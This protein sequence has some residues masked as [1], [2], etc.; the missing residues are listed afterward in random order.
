MI[1]KKPMR[2]GFT[3]VELLV[4][5]AIIG[6]LVGLLLPAVQAAREAAR[7]MSCSNNLKQITL[8]CHNYHDT[9]KQWPIHGTG[10]EDANGRA[11]WSG[12]GDL[13]SINR[14]G[15]FLIGVLPFIEQQ[16]LWD[17]ISNPLA[18]ETDGS[19]KDPAWQPMGPGVGRADYGP[20]ATEISAFRCPSDPGQGL[21]SL[22]RTNYAANM[23]DSSCMTREGP[24]NVDDISDG[25]TVPYT[26]NQQRQAE[27]SRM[28][29]RG[30]FVNFKN[31]RI[32][33]YLDGASNTVMV[34]E[35][36]TDLG[37]L[38]KRTSM[39]NAPYQQSN[40]G[41]TREC[42][43]DPNYAEVQGWFNPQR[44]QFWPEDATQDNVLDGR[45]FRW[46][47]AQHIFTQ[48]HT[49]LPPNS[50]LCTAGRISR[51]SLNP[52][53]SRHP[54]GVH[55]GMADG[56]VRFITDSIESGNPTANMVTYYGDSAGAGVASPYGLWGALGTRANREVID[57]EF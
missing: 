32:R 41:R 37:D 39:P 7:R 33:D 28:C 27:R 26:Q 42:Y 36:A 46:Y 11:P 17:Q 1:P 43:R 25:A 10:N 13:V 56:S 24:L 53:S 50:G 44:P 14:Q 29:H 22:G 51:D 45:G 40:N 23:G 47:A 2:T 4:V 30:A 57:G 49:I 34:G 3:L 19:V 15:S 5:I 31:M 20:W 16:A 52:A 54:G 8:G 6:V 48:F 38:D 21:P 12:S 55:I 9:F 35:I 18:V